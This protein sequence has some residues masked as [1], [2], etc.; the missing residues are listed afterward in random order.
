MKKMTKDYAEALFELAEECS[1]EEKFLNQLKFVL[2]EMSEEYLNL[3]S[4]PTLPIQKR[5]K[6]IE[7]A[8]S[9]DVHKYV[10]SFIQLLCKNEK[11]RRFGNCVKEYESL[12]QNHAHVFSARITSAVQLSENEK[13]ALENKLEKI[14]HGKITAV[15][16]TDTE[17]I[18]GVIVRID[19]K[20]IDGSIRT[21]LN[22]LKDVIDK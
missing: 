9:H 21:K 5:Q 4:S 19:G 20:V 7:E 2:H 6:L 10:L 12:C 13:K 22:K 11:I 18:G 3:L 14:T 17:I 15:Y 16:E 8:F 1:S